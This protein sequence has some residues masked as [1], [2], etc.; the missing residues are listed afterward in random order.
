M[1]ELF[2]LNFYS[3]V[4][5]VIWYSF[6]NSIIHPVDDKKKKSRSVELYFNLVSWWHLAR[7]SLV[8]F[9]GVNLRSETQ[10]FFN[11]D[12]ES[13]ISYPAFLTLRFGYS[14]LDMWCQI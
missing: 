14:D 9:N 2:D 5:A 7:Y 10:R 12:L 11:P 6:Y 8:N 3:A 4:T 1:L 13:L